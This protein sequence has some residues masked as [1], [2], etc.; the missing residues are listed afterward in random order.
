MTSLVLDCRA[1]LSI[2]ADGAFLAALFAYTRMTEGDP[3]TD[4]SVNGKAFLMLG[5]SEALFFRPISYSGG[6]H[7]SFN[8]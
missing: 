8:S 7:L 6:K 3:M 1:G 2:Q 5:G 4:D